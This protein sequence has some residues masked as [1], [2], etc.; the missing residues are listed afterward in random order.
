VRHIARTPCVNAALF[1]TRRA[2]G[3]VC[4]VG[5]RVSRAKQA[6]PIEMLFALRLPWWIQGT[7]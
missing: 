4:V 6:E 3:V 1:Y 7:V 2:R 5:T